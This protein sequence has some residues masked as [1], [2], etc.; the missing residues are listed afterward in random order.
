MPPKPTAAPLD[1]DLL[2]AFR[3]QGA[4]IVA[5]ERGL[6]AVCR[7]KLARL[8]G[9][10]GIPDEQIDAAIR[11]LHESGPKA[12]PNPLA[13]KFRDRLRKD[14]AG[15]T[16]AIIGP[17]IEAE[18]IAAA[19][20][21]Y[22]LDEPTSRQV[23]GEVAEEIGVT[24]ITATDAIDSLATQIEQTVGESTWLAREAWDRLRTA[25]AK[26]GIEL[27][28]VDELIDEKLAAN[29]EEARGR[30]FWTRMTLTAAGGGAALVGVVILVLLVIRANKTP[31]VP[32]E[33]PG[34]AAAQAAPI[35]PKVATA[36]AWWD[37]DLSV[38]MATAETKFDGLSGASVLMK[39][40]I[41]D[42]RASGYERMIELVK[43]ASGNE[44]LLDV[45]ARI[46]T[47]CHALEPDESA[48]GRLRATLLALLPAA[49]APLPTQPEQYDLAYWAAETA[50]GALH[51]EGAAAD[52]T[53]KLADA[54]SAAL[55]AP[56]DPAF[57]R[58]ANLHAARVRTTLAA[59]QQ[60]T[61]AASKQPSAAALLY[62]HLAPRAIRFI[63]DEELTKAE[64]SLLVAALPTAD[65]DWHAYDEAIV[66]CTS[67]AD[68]LNVLRLTDTLQRC[69]DK[70]LVDTLSRMLVLRAGVTP[71]TW[72]K[73]DV[74]KAVRKALGA[75]GA[76]AGST[77]A[78]RWLVLREAADA[79]LARPAPP[80]ANQ[81]ELLSQ[82]I[83]LAHLT[84]M[85]MA[86]A[87]GEAGFASFD[88]GM[89]ESPELAQMTSRGS[90]V[91]EPKA[92]GSAASRSPR[93]LGPTDRR[94]LE[95]FQAMLGGFARMQPV[96]RVTALR[97]LALLGD[98]T[99]DIAPQYAENAAKYLLFD[100]ADDEHA[101]V[102]RILPAI[103]HWKRLR[104]AVADLVL[105]S[106]LTAAQ[107]HELGR[108][109]LA[110]DIPPD[111]SS[112]GSLHRLLLESVL[113]EAG[114]A[115]SRAESPGGDSGEVFD[116]A[117]R[118]LAETYRQ[119]ARLLSISGP[120]LA[121]AQT[122]SQAL[123]LVLRPIAQSLHGS[124]EDASF[125]ANLD[126]LRTAA[127]F[128]AG[129]DLRQTVALQRLM[130]EL[131]TR[132]VIRQRPQQAATA[133][134][135]ETESL[136]KISQPGS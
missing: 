135:I 9:S 130:V 14:L 126:H 23:L 80:T 77:A 35:T 79:A 27:E 51:R 16:R 125:V 76:T 7:V 46:F 44:E 84:T 114:E 89:T 50:A 87:Q 111:A 121:E 33:N 47:G 102:L 110:R 40:E 82:T 3:Q 70:E 28:V 22:S 21:K 39:S 119:R 55:S 34:A 134:Q 53:R 6:T 38:E 25:G 118:L 43:S 71:A 68:P 11:A 94:D 12:P 30:R 131:S 65:E 115:A 36:P 24:R 13:E 117:A 18:I 83:E 54:L 48:A 90:V 62:T 74:V 57:G 116:A 41:P 66:R 101:E 106:R 136:A 15:K 69:T 124:A 26:W 120:P 61:A 8:A 5:Q 133:R 42:E 112:G 60:L 97:G 127:A 100:K 78:D 105:Q 113:L 67:S 91:D 45:A 103:R 17:T 73:T 123:D 4:A 108:T 37:V 86:L 59:Y 75:A 2:A 98:K 128:L 99:G 10:L 88:A 56:F 107:Q 109:L 52:R 72:E 95:R 31:D 63:D 104:L 58:S 19:A 29:R 122:P 132:R 96:Q 92:T 20:R 49:D 81:H 32:P 93:S 64:T 129:D 1:P 85:A